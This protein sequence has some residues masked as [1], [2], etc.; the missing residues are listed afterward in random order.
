MGRTSGQ[1]M[2]NAQLGLIEDDMAD[3]ARGF[4]AL[5]RLWARLLSLCD[6]PMGFD[7][8]DMISKELRELE[9][10]CMAGQRSLIRERERA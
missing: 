2:P 5:E 7:D 6:R 10:A 3:V 4:M 9:V 8:I 1:F